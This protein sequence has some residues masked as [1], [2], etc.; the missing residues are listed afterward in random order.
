[1]EIFRLNGSWALK[2]L[3]ICE[4]GEGLIKL[5]KLI[6]VIIRRERILIDLY[7]VK[8]LYG[9]VL[10]HFPSTYLKRSTDKFSA[11]SVLT[12]FFFSITRVAKLKLILIGRIPMK[13]RRENLALKNFTIFISR[14]RHLTCKTS[15]SLRRSLT[16]FRFGHHRDPPSC[17]GW[18]SR[19][20]RGCRGTSTPAHPRPVPCS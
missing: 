20:C 17:K 12:C 16:S 6:E 7:Y 2:Y 8:L 10:N 3:S 9:K 4:F 19:F 11:T 1:M 5:F 15:V 14:P 18:T 13:I